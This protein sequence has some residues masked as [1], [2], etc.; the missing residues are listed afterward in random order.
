M[1]RKQLFK[2]L[3]HTIDPDPDRPGLIETPERMHRAWLE[4]FNGYQQN[5]ANV[6]KIF[7]P[8]GEREPGQLVLLKN[9]EFTSFCEHHMMPFTGVAHIAYIPNKNVLGASKLARLL[10]IYARRLQIQERIGEQVTCALMAFLKPQGA[11]CILKARH[12]C[13]SGRGVLKQKSK[14]VTASLKGCFLDEAT[15]RAEL[16]S[17]IKI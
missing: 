10:E 11:A 2:S 4:F 5:P 16:Y 1:S 15:T 13:I 17:M 3:L 8:E 14:L 6:F 12:L 9:I 7:S